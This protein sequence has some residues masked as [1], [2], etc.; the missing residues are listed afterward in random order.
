VKHSGDQIRVP[1]GDYDWTDEQERLWNDLV[2]RSGQATTVQGELIRCLGRLTDE[3][4]RNGNMNW[5]AEFV[6]MCEFVERT[7]SDPATFSGE[8]L[9]SIRDA[10]RDIRDYEHPDTSGH[11]SAHYF[12]TEMAVR[13]CFEHPRL[14]ARAPDPELRR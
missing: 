3:A 14:V 13:W 12:L 7:L 10:L 8:Q 2:P 6:R 4:Y 5:D 9:D 1:P 11:G